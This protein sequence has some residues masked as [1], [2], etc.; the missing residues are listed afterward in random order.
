MEREFGWHPPTTSP[1]VLSQAPRDEG[2]VFAS[3]ATCLLWYPQS[4]L[5]V[6]P[7]ALLPVGHMWF[8]V[9]TSPPSDG[10]LES[11]PLSV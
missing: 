1:F 6:S 8:P 10:P 4:L 5:L 2:L 9:V 7:V 11:G 3:D